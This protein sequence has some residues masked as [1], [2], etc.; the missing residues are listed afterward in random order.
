M[1]C[2]KI[3]NHLGFSL[4]TF[5]DNQSLILLGIFL[6]LAEE[7][8]RAVQEVV[9]YCTPLFAFLN[10]HLPTLWIFLKLPFMIVNFIK[11]KVVN[12]SQLVLL[13]FSS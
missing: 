3:R 11:A 10:G 1:N 9:F 6:S 4:E 5:E 13:E 8:H 12:L 7:I 2:T